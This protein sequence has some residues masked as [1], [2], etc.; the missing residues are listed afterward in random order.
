M[1]VP[2]CNVTNMHK[3]TKKDQKFLGLVLFLLI[4]IKYTY[5]KIN[6]Y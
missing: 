2:S 4:V 1:V 5:H 6:H 3:M